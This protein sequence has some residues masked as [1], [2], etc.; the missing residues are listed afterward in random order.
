MNRFILHDGP[1]RDNLLPLTFTRSVGDIR[2]GLFTIAEKWEKF[3]GL[4]VSQL[5]PEYL[6][7][8]YAT[9]LMTD[10][11]IIRSGVLPDKSLVASILQL[12]PNQVLNKNQQWIA[13]RVESSVIGYDLP[14]FD[15]FESIAYSND[16][17]QIEYPWDIFRF[18]GVELKSDFDFILQ[19]G[20]E[21][22][23]SSTNR[24]IGNGRLFI[25]NEA[26]VEASTINTSTG[27]VYIG[28][29]AEV[30]EGCLIRG[31]FA[32][33]NHSTLKMGAKIYGA[34][35]IGPYCKVGGEL[36]NV[37]MFGYSNKAHDGFL[38]NSVIG[39][40]CNLG[41]D[42]NC[43][44]LK[45]NYLE[46]KS[47]NYPKRGFIKTGLQ[48]CGLIMGDHSKSG[49]NTMFNTGTVVGVSANIYGSGF[50]RSFIPSFC[51]GGEH[52]LEDYNID[53]A[54]ETAKL[55]IERRGMSL[56]AVDEEILRYIYKIKTQL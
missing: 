16:I 48:F 46:V 14:H 18:N 55:V 49:I 11:C 7:Q 20:G 17:R 33:C 56:S 44:N 4:K 42:T 27:D 30:M 25:H 45:N 13:A 54:I 22:N 53:Q 26:T 31:P 50:P 19:Q 36:N 1:N 28:P 32:L 23:L 24:V 12:K 2:V 35:T 51:R 8:K 6:K 52:G 9:E 41:A 34:T 39:H 5:V 47:W 15:T 43:S 3:L 40:W 21:G 29:G 37:V 10:C 38:G